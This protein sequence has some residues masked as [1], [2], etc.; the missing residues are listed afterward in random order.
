MNSSQF[1]LGAHTSTSGGIHNALKEGMK[2]GASSI[3]LF[4]SNQHRW[5]SSTFTPKQIDLWYK[6]LESTGIRKISSH[7]SYL[8]NLGAPNPE[9]LEKSRNAIYEELTRCI[10]LGIDFLTFHP[11]A[12]IKSPIQQ[13][14]N[15]IIESLI[16]LENLSQTGSTRLLLECTAGQGSIIGHKFEQIAEIINGVKNYIPIGVCIDTCHAFAAGYDI[17]TKETLE[18]TLCDFNNIIGMQYLYAF[19]LNDSKFPLNSHRDRHAPLGQGEI[20]ME[21]FKTLMTH[22][23]TKY[24]PKYLETPGGPNLWK[25]EISILKEYVNA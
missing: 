6:T 25:K 19:H 13:C 16:A 14:I 10:D 23:Q 4:T 8:I 1:F 20:G 21:C 15:R 11:G 9:T 12:A 22:P 17:R 24:I 2:I 7:A 5:K 3:Q 18:K